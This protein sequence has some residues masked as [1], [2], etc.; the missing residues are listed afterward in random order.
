MSD[1]FTI[2]AVV[3]NDGGKGASRRLRRE[4]LVPGIIYGGGKDPEMIAATH[5]KLLQ[6]L[7][8]EAFYSSIVEVEV[9][10]NMQR[11]VLKDL[12]RHP[13]KPFVMHFDLQRVA[14]TDRIK[15]HV[16]LHFIGEENAPG[17]KAGGI[18]SH[19]LVDLE[20][21]CEAQNLP[22]YIEVDVSAMD[23]GDMLHLTDVNLPEGVEIVAMTHGDAHEHDELVVSMQAQAKVVDEEEAAPEADA[24]TEENPSSEEE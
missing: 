20:I 1:T 7:E 8:H 22:E 17:I 15:M 9:D 13:A 14:A 24:E 6:H 19:A 3:R 10:G 12:Q 4:G 21:I 2:Q 18:V 16:P 5:N 23:V 11:V